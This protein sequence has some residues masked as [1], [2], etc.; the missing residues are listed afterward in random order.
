MQR[1]RERGQRS[2]GVQAAEK[3]VKRAFGSN[4]FHSDLEAMLD[5]PS[6]S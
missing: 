5:F 6:A 4:E 3:E 2:N 1:G